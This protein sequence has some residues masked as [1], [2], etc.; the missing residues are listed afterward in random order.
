MPVTV[1]GEAALAVVPSP[2]A[3]YEFSPQHAIC[4][5]DRS[6][7]ACALPAATWIA[8]SGSPTTTGD[9][10]STRAPLPS[11]PLVPEPQQTVCPSFRTAQAKPLPI[12]T[13]RASDGELARTG[14]P[15]L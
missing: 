2:S 14:A 6:A 12:D 3:P 7:H 10:E 9:T 13:E 8:S 4:P 11:W 1:T 5:F 15:A